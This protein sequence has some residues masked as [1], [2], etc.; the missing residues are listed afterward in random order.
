MTLK[1][2]NLE[3]P[4]RKTWNILRGLVFEAH[5]LL[6]HSTLGLRVIK[7][8]KKTPDPKILHQGVGLCYQLGGG[9]ISVL[10]AFISHQVPADI[11]D[12]WFTDNWFTDDWFTDNTTLI[13]W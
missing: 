12:N 9:N 13:Y 7:K 8:K 11:A 3:P 6:Y 1:P 10:S 2:W 5:R 4:P